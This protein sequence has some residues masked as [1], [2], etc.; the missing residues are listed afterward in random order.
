M[1]GL[2]VGDARVL[3]IALDAGLCRDFHDNFSRVDG[4]SL[5]LQ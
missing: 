4:D 5:I 3:I 1:G 2:Q